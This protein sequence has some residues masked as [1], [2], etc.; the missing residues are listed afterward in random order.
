MNSFED[1]KATLTDEQKIEITKRLEEGFAEKMMSIISE[2]IPDELSGYMPD[3]IWVEDEHI[4]RDEEAMEFLSD[5]A[6][7]LLAKKF[8]S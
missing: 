8:T 4:S 5:E 6:W 7:R 3:W 1:T 2:A